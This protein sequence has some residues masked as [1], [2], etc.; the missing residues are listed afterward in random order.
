[1][2]LQ[3]EY[4]ELQ[5]RNM[6]LERRFPRKVKQSYSQRFEAKVGAESKV[7]V[8][9][10]ARTVEVGSWLI[11]LEVLERSHTDSLLEE[12]IET[13]DVWPVPPPGPGRVDRLAS[14][15]IRLHPRRRRVVVTPY[16]SLFE[17]LSLAG[18]LFAMVE[19]AIGRPVQL[20]VGRYWNV[21]MSELVSSDALSKGAMLPSGDLRGVPAVIEAV[22]TA[23]RLQRRHTARFVERATGRRERRKKAVAKRFVAEWVRRVQSKK[24][25]GKSDRTASAG[26]VTP[27]VG[28]TSGSMWGSGELSRRA[29]P[30]PSPEV[31]GSTA[32][33]VEAPL[34][35]AHAS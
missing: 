35:G 7:E 21:L 19:F 20:M 5:L 32:S 28:D 3:A 33:D 2:S 34:P 13:T 15:Y 10:Q 9:F 23:Q 25:S 26:D 8:M 24:S 4:N 31:Q 27:H 22:S 1:V 14:F 12:V 11:D 30:P 6:D 16:P 17:L 29:S 18:G